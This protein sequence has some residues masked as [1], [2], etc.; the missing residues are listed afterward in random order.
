MDHQKNRRYFYR[1]FLCYKT[2]GDSNGEKIVARQF[3]LAP[4]SRHLLFVG[5][6]RIGAESPMDVMFRT[7]F[8]S[9]SG[10]R[11]PFCRPKVD[12]SPKRGIPPWITKINP[13][14][15]CW[16]GLFLYLSC[17]SE[18]RGSPAIWWAYF[19][20]Q[21]LGSAPHGRVSPMNYIPDGYLFIRIFTTKICLWFYQQPPID[22]AVLYAL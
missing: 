7:G 13:I 11:Q 10:G 16:L 19:D 15:F 6:G 12:I 2:K 22:L 9:P 4:N 20:E 17:Y 1:L 18:R 14:N 5:E 21:G 3:V 8:R